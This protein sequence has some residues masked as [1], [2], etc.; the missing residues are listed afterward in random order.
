[1]RTLVRARASEYLQYFKVQVLQTKYLKAQVL[2]T[3]SSPHTLHP[4]L[5]ILHSTSYTL[6][7]TPNTQTPYTL[8]P[9]PYTLHPT[10]LGWGA[11]VGARASFEVAHGKHRREHAHLPLEVRKPGVF[12]TRSFIKVPFSRRFV[13]T[14][15]NHGGS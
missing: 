1:M 2:D 7:P 9:S 5:Y 11:N 6:H 8:H 14:P 13:T 3:S 15:H 4:T 10:P 12:K